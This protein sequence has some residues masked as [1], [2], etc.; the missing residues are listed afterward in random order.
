MFSSQGDIF[1]PQ[2]G[3]SFTT[4]EN[5]LG[6]LAS[7][8]KRFKGSRK[9]QNPKESSFEKP[10]KDR[11]HKVAKEELTTFDTNADA[12]SKSLSNGYKL[13][14]KHRKVSKQNSY[15]KEPDFRIR[16][17]KNKLADYLSK[18]KSMSNRPLPV[19]ERG[20]E[21]SLFPMGNDFD[22]V[23]Q[24]YNSSV[25]SPSSAGGFP[26][27]FD[28]EEEKLDENLYAEIGDFY[29]GDQKNSLRNK[30]EA[31]IC[32]NNNSRNSFDPSQWRKSE[33]SSDFELNKEKLKMMSSHA[34]VDS[35]CEGSIGDDPQSD[36]EDE[37]YKLTKEENMFN[38]SL[39]M[40][41]DETE[42]L[43]EAVVDWDIPSKKWNSSYTSYS[44]AYEPEKQDELVSEIEDRNINSRLDSSS[45]VTPYM[46]C[47]T[48]S[49]LIKISNNSDSV[50]HSIS[51][52]KIGSENFDDYDNS[53]PNVDMKNGYNRHESIT[54]NGESI[55]SI[56]VPGSGTNQY[57]LN[58]S[59]ENRNDSA[60]CFSTSP[61]NELVIRC[62]DTSLSDNWK[63]IYPS[64]SDSGNASDEV[65]DSEHS[66]DTDSLVDEFESNTIDDVSNM[67]KE[68]RS[69]LSL[70]SDQLKCLG[71]SGIINVTETEDDFDCHGFSTDVDLTDVDRCR[72]R[73][74]A[75]TDE[76]LSC[77]GQSDKSENKRQMRPKPFTSLETKKKS[78]AHDLVEVDNLVFK[79]DHFITLKDDLHPQEKT[80]KNITHTGTFFVRDIDFMNDDDENL[81][82]PLH[83]GNEDRS[84][85]PETLLI[86]SCDENIKE[87][88]EIDDVLIP[89]NISLDSLKPFYNSPVK[90]GNKTSRTNTEITDL[91]KSLYPI[92][93]EQTSEEVSQN[94]EPADN[95]E[96]SSNQKFPN[97][98]KNLGICLINIR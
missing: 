3:V 6:K 41:E 50:S 23:N 11:R 21:V 74:C 29:K 80:A 32:K 90:G 63:E 42:Q 30:I 53:N 76:Q 58:H 87:D 73:L 97:S 45:T 55:V 28:S 26:Y 92:V 88:S 83:N 12:S 82:L 17:K 1:A 46:G 51:S 35:D 57:A 78:E 48:H 7:K 10:T 52:I 24:D 61:S 4:S 13:F 16:S 43:S 33:V 72:D 44:N 59:F 62:G 69:D 31:E 77:M 60:D 65:N 95:S 66:F 79:S 27:D 5:H 81:V 40:D 37:C 70:K 84:I 49:T 91:S 2:H 94:L 25:K 18:N 15:V 9:R 67:N 86:D 39:S 89:D 56:I 47:K 8:V 22:S 85:E 14:T 19:P 71:D 34:F 75:I 93:E 68:L 54:Y 38:D 96:I 64:S 20:D 98:D 36:S